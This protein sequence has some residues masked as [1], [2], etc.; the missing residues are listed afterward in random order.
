MSAKRKI[1]VVDDE[2]TLRDMFKFILEKANYEVIQ[3]SDGASGVAQSRSEKPDLVILDGLMP[4]MHGFLACEA[5]KKQE[6]PPKVIILTGVYTN[7]RYKMEAKYQ[8][9]A[10]EFLTKPISPA[11][12]LACVEKLLDGLPQRQAVLQQ[13]PVAVE[14][15]ERL[16]TG[17]RERPAA[18]AP[19]RSNGYS[20]TWKSILKVE[21]VSTNR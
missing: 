9:K 21:P 11:N 3:A 19:V 7:P 18:S 6:N 13:Q 16:K 17:D 4:K 14:I 1:L 10:D 2:A 12:L 8:Y 15:F 5:I 20:A